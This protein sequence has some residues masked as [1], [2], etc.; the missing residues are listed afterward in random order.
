MFPEVAGRNSV[1]R[2]LRRNSG[3]VRSGGM[4]RGVKTRDKNSA[5][6][7]EPTQCEFFG[8]QL[9]RDSQPEELVRDHA[10]CFLVSS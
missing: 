8:I 3:Q 6:F 4:W 1:C 7:S 10:F 9:T 2:P 5:D